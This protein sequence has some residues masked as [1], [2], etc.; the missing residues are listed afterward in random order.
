METLCISRQAYVEKAMGGTQ[1]F[2]WH[3][4]FK[5]R[6]K[7]SLEDAE[8]AGRLVTSLNPRKCGGNP[9]QHVHEEY[10]R[11]N[12]QWQFEGFE[13][14]H[15]AKAVG[16]LERKELNSSRRVLF[17]REFLAKTIITSLPHLPY[18][19]DPDLAPADFHF[20]HNTS[21]YRKGHCSQNPLRIENCPRLAYEKP[22]A[23][24]IPKRKG[25][26][27]LV[28]RSTR[29]PFRRRWG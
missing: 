29:Q 12:N 17:N 1:Y 10:Q 23:F 9:Y 15:W 4:R 16:F 14:R 21:M 27:G 18:S 20:F 24:R 6:E 7:T 19:P 8:R 5:S 11:T 3:G 26:F 28:Y 22:L 25:T 2:V 13:G